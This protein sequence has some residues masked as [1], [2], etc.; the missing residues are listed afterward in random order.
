MPHTRKP[1]IRQQMS[2]HIKICKLEL[3]D[4]YRHDKNIS[5]IILNHVVKQ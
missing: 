5:K 3:H 2:I 1:I 4:K